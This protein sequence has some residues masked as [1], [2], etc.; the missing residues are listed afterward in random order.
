MRNYPISRQRGQIIIFM[1]FAMIPIM[2]LM[3]S[4][5]N[6]GFLVVQKTRLQNATDTAVLMEASWTA[7]SMNIMSMNNT[8]LTQAQAITSTAWAMEKPLM[9]AGLTAGL[10]AGFYAGRMVKISTSCP[11]PC[12]IIAPFVYG[13]LYGLLDRYVLEPLYDLQLE[14]KRAIHTDEDQGF[15]KAATSFGRMNKILSEK[16][17]LEIE[18]Y[19][20][21]LL[22]ANYSEAAT[23]IRYNA[24]A[25][26]DDTL[27]V[28]IPVVEQSLG[29]ALRDLV[30]AQEDSSAT[31]EVREEDS[32]TS[33]N[34]NDA[35][36]RFK[37]LKDVYH[38]GLLGTHTNP[39][40]VS[41]PYV[42]PALNYFGNFRAQGYADGT[43]PFPLVHTEL[44]DVFFELFT[45]LE[46][47]VDG[48]GI[49][50]AVEGALEDRFN[51]G[52]WVGDIIFAPI[53]ALF[54]AAIAPFLGTAYEFQDTT[55]ADFRERMDNVWEWSTYYGESH[56][57]NSWRV[58]KR[59]D[60]LLF[61]LSAPPR[62]WRGLGFGFYH[63]TQLSNAFDNF[64]QEDYDD[65]QEAVAAQTGEI[66]PQFM[67][68][69]FA[70][71]SPP[72]IERYERV[73]M[74]TRGAE[75]DGWTV[76]QRGGRTRAQ[77]QTLTSEDTR[78]IAERVQNE[79]TPECEAEYQE[80]VSNNIGEPTP[81]I[82]ASPAGDSQ[83]E[84]VVPAATE[85]ETHQGDVD[86]YNAA[87]GQ[88]ETSGGLDPVSVQNY[89]ELGNW[90]F[91][92]S[93]KIIKQA[94]PIDAIANIFIPSDRSET[95][96]H[97][98]CGY[99][100]G[101]G[102]LC[103]NEAAMYAVRGQRITPEFLSDLVG[104]ATGLDASSLP[105][106]IQ[107]NY[108][109]QRE[110]W[111]LLI[112]AT[113]PIVLPIAANGFDG[114]PTEGM[115]AI[116]QAEVFNSQWF[117]LFTQTWKA[118]LTPISLLKHETHFDLLKASWETEAYGFLDELTVST[119]DDQRVINH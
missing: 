52:G 60:L 81:G 42:L 67:E 91:E 83:P 61:D 28:Q 9:D 117:D 20:N 11:F 71:K 100:F 79:L 74:A 112:S 18:D 43:G 68:R 108:N 12:A 119:E 23:M 15:A 97:W 109:S 32:S 98:W 21:R 19:S 103:T 37:D 29:D 10:V 70:E 80:F 73:L 49:S 54:D 40:T 58:T 22:A 17:P 82:E 89:L 16:F 101:E 66:R 50:D 87:Q 77:Y 92:P 25:D 53:K 111:S 104:G 59:V 30:P 113:A 84:S 93:Y 31:A 78:L 94:F 62:M 90:F 34:I 2:L 44:N 33:A 115:S 35:L 76:A 114:V 118:K 27:R 51:P 110:D 38:A 107:E 46:G 5:W 4:I 41:G 75:W 106:A 36:A 47:Y 86:D 6:G 24:W 57:S 45:T 13:I 105:E 3:A 96:A 8:A 26:S 55:P 63:G 56:Y 72:L 39:Y 88:E 14:L 64:S 95:E 65:S 116:S 7:R 99:P 102:A 69:C 48:S 85:E 1:M